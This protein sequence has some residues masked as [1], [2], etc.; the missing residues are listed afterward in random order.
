MKLTLKKE[1]KA[2]LKL[3]IP[4]KDAM[5]LVIER[6]KEVAYGIKYGIYPNRRIPFKVR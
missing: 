5:D 3:N 2:I 1:I 6:V 4:D